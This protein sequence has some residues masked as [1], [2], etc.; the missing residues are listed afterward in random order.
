ATTEGVA[1]APGV[2]QN[3]G[4]RTV[5]VKRGQLTAAV[6]VPGTIGWDL[7]QERIVSARVDTIV[8]RLH[9]RAPFEPVHAGQPLASIIAPTWGTAIAEARAL[10]GARSAAAR[11]LQS[12]A[13][14]RL[15]ALGLPA[16]SDAGQ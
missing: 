4:I 10:G 11:G 5:V 6:R 14:E 15:R 16:G 13:H 9:V 12:A 1:V 2:R 7:R 8:E 3:L